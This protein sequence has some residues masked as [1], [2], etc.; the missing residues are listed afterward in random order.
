MR[1]LIF[2]TFLSLMAIAL[3]IIGF[4]QT[5]TI[6]TFISG[7]L[8]MAVICNPSLINQKQEEK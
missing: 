6:A 5:D 8:F 2:M 7:A 4:T 3:G 1:K